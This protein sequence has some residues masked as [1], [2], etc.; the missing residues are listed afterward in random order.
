[1]GPTEPVRRVR[2]WHEESD[3]VLGVV[4]V[5]E[6]PLTRMVGLLGRGALAPGEGLLL[7]PCA[8]IHTC[9]MRFAIDVVFTDRTGDVVGV[10]DTLRPFR[11]ARGGRGAREA[12]ELPAGTVRRAR[13]TPG[14]RVRVEPV[15]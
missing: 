7:R 11:L 14:G 8:M 13:V 1:M 10:F 9:F 5:A 15:E 4:D 6:T 12:I 3:T 2:V